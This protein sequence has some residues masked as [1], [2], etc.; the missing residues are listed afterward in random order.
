MNI[1]TNITTIFV[2]E[3]INNMLNGKEY[4]GDKFYRDQKLTGFG[5]K[6]QRNKVSY[7]AEIKVK[8]KNYRKVI[9]NAQVISNSQAR[10]LAK[11]FLGDMAVGINVIEQKKENKVKAITL[12]QA[13][14][15][16]LQ[17]RGIKEKTLKE[18]KLFIYKYLKDWNDK[19]LNKITDDMVTQFYKSKKDTP[20]LANR[21][22]SV[23]S[24]IY[25]YAMIKYKHG[26]KL[27]ITYNPCIILKTCKKYEEKSREIMVEQYDIAKFW[28]ATE[29][30]RYDT[31]KMK[32]TKKLCRLCILTGCR[33]QEICRLK[34][35]DVDRINK[36]FIIP[37]TKNGRAH[38]IAYGK[39]TE[40][41]IDKLCEGL[42]DD[43]YLFPAPTESGHL[44]NHSKYIK[45]LNIAAGIKFGLHDLRRSFTSYAAIFLKMDHCIVNVMTN[46]KN[47]DVTYDSY[48]KVGA[49]CFNVYRESFQMIEDFILKSANQ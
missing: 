20:Y 9:G 31:Q 10:E 17:A 8:G 40:E 3:L 24:A 37:D 29:E 1:R 47:K 44:E 32:Q 42:S 34:R 48:V 11:K 16:Y 12:K 35:K 45:K 15:D 25:N 28:A 4:D 14:N 21:I 49:S 19:P 33:E 13:F 7:I 2:K 26:N 22:M 41:I 38:T 36:I 43:D 6:L 18:Y 5:I 39:Y 23:L 46:H 30:N 27:L